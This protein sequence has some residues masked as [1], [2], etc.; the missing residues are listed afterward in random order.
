MNDNPYRL[1]AQRLDSLPNG[2][3]ATEDDSELRLLACLFTPEEADLA[4]RLRLTRET[5]GQIAGTYRRR[6]R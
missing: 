3:P 2:F 5:P 4:A 6:P 1:L